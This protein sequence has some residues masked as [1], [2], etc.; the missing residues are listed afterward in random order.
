MALSQQLCLPDLGHFIFNMG[1]TFKNTLGDQ[2][3]GD[4]TGDSQEQ[5]KKISPMEA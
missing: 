4:K 1:Y 3:R 2:G 5:S